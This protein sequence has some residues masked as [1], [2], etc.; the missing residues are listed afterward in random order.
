MNK[1]TLKFLCSIKKISQSDLAREIGVSRQ[2]VSRWFLTDKTQSNIYS[3]HQ[4]RI[5]NYFGLTF[6]ELSNPLPIISNPE[7]RKKVETQ[8]L[9]DKLFRNLEEYL[10]ALVRGNLPAMARLVQ[11]YGLYPSYQM[12]G[13]VILKKFPDYKRIIHPALREKFEVLWKFY[14]K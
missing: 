13:N 2:I 4:E 14:L 7:E 6:E 8:L 11:V 9:W 12:M 10:S 3:L 1:A 5:A